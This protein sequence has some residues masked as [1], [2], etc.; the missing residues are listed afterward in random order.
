MRSSDGPCP[1]LAANIVA[2]ITLTKKTTAKPCLEFFSDGSGEARR[3]VIENCPFRI[4]RAESADLRVESVEVSREHV[5]ITERNG[6]WLVRDLGSTNGTQVNGKAITETLLS[7]GDILRVAE[8]EMTFIASAVSQFQRMVTQPIQSRKPVATPSALLPEV[9]GIRM[10]T[11][12]TLYQKIPTKLLA[13]TSL[14]SGVTEAYFA[15]ATTNAKLQPILDQPHAVGERYR[16]LERTRALE[17]AT[18]HTD[19]RRLYLAVGSA[20]IEGPHRLFSSLKQL[21]A[22]LPSGWELGI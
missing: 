14:R 4:G 8:T 1:T 5:E 2:H 16:E 6:M 18:K 13:A 17:L 7:D 12:A 9:A 3:V 22:M 19:A 20:D 11:E 10:M 15:P 21:Q